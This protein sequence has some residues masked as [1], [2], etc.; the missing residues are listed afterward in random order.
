MSIIGKTISQ[1]MKCQHPYFDD[2][3]FL[4]LIFNDGSQCTIMS[5]YTGFTGE[6]YGEY[7]TDIAVTMGECKLDDSDMHSYG[8]EK[9]L[10]LIPLSESPYQ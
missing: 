1:V 6:S 5:C 2:K 9:K 7:P 8:E 10:P 3:G 4:T